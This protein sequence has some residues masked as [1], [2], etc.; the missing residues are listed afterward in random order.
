ML[1]RDQRVVFL[2]QAGFA[3]RRIVAVDDSP[4]GN[5]IQ[6]A[7]CVTHC[8]RG[9][10]GITTS[11][12]ELGL[13]HKGASLGAIGTIA[14]SLLLANPDTLFS[15]FVICQSRFTSIDSGNHDHRSISTPRSCARSSRRRG[16][17]VTNCECSS[18]CEA[19][20]VDGRSDRRIFDR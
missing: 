6:C 16:A 20:V 4:I 3:P 17:I 18:Q 9:H 10:I 7:D 19:N 11:N 1:A 5:P 15:R 2:H 14:K 12:R 13:F 8:T